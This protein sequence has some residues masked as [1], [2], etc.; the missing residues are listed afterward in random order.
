MQLAQTLLGQGLGARMGPSCLT[1]EHR[2]TWLLQPCAEG[3]QQAQVG[4]RG[5]LQWDNA[6]GSS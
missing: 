1:H 5:T 4:L 6:L 2:F 3:S